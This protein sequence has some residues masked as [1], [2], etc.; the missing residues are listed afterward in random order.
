[1]TT[2][3]L[4][5]KCVV[6]AVV[7]VLDSVQTQ[8]TTSS[9][10]LETRAPPTS[11]QM[12]AMDNSTQRVLQLKSSA[13]LVVEVFNGIPTRFRS[14]QRHLRAPTTMRHVIFSSITSSLVTA[15]DIPAPI[16]ACFVRTGT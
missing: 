12:T 16:S 1:M 15:R 14:P 13:V 8:I 7:P 3:L 10:Q 9:T 2:T 4:L 6:D 5:L 11:L